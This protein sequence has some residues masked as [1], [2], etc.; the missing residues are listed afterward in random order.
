ML[1]SDLIDLDPVALR[2]TLECADAGAAVDATQIARLQRD[3]AE[4]VLAV[5]A[6]G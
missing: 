4:V 6:G 1:P 3:G 2:L 5:S